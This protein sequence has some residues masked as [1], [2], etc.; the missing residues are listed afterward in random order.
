[1]NKHK[2]F[3]LIE[4]LVAVFIFI[5]LFMITASLVN[6]AAGSA[7]SMR[8]KMLTTDIRNTMDTISQKMNNANQKA[9]IGTDVINGFFVQN[10]ILGIATTTNGTDKKCVFIGK[11]SDNSIAMLEDANCSRSSWPT[12][13][14]LSQKLTGT[15]VKITNNES[16]PTERI[17]ILSNEVTAVSTA[18]PNLKVYIK[19]QDADAKWQNDNQITLQTTYTMDYMTIKR[20]QNL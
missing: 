12:T 16:L 20:L 19:A 13:L 1:M 7:K 10:Y 15:G 8:T 5:V 18:A 4:L 17:F 11:K 9:T 3:T 6:L 2:S 14:D